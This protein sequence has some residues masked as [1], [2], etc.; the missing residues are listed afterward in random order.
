M[1]DLFYI[2]IYVDL[3]KENTQPKKKTETGRELKIALSKP[4]EYLFLSP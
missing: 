4:Y 1:R 2:A 3:K